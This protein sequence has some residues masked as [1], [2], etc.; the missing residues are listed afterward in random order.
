[1]KSSDSSDFVKLVVNPKKS[2]YSSLITI[3]SRKREKRNSE[4][5]KKR[6]FKFFPYL[7]LFN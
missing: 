3:A 6:N 2:L 7:P 5:V 1:M 4:E